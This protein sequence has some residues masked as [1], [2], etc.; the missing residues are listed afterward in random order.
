MTLK[1]AIISLNLRKINLNVDRDRPLGRQRDIHHGIRLE[2]IEYALSLLLDIDQERYEREQHPLRII[3]S[4]TF[5]S[6]DDWGK[7]SRGDWPDSTFGRV[8]EAE[9]GINRFDPSRC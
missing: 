5:K 4:I 7:Q 3:P 2:E 8:D 9:P 6:D 1:E